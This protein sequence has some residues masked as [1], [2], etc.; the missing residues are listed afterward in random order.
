MVSMD[1]FNQDP[2]KTIQLTAAIEK[3]PYVP[4][5]LETLKVFVDKPIRTDTLFVEQRDGQ[6]SL[7]P[8]TDR[9]APRTQR[10]T[11]RR[12]ARPFVVPRISMADT[13]YAHE[14]AFIRD[15]G[16]ESA[17]M[18]IQKE[19]MRRT[20]GPTGLR[21]NLRFTQENHKLATIQGYL[22]DS[23][24]S[25]KFNWFSEFG[26]TPNDATYFD[27]TSKTAGMLRPKIANIVR[28]MKR[29]SK[30]AFT[31]GT[32]VYAL[33]GDQFWD[34]FITHPDIEKTYLNW[35]AAA[36]LRGGTAFE[37]YPFADVQWV[38]YRG[39]D[40]TVS[41]QA[42]LTNGSADA[43]VSASGLAQLTDGWYASGYGVPA[44]S[45]I[46]KGSGKITLS[47][48]FTGVTGTYLLNFGPSENGGG[49]ISIPTNKC[50]F[51]PVGAP[52]VFLRALAPAESVEFLGTLGKPEYLRMIPDRDRNEWVKFEMDSYP[53]HICTRPEMLFSGYCGAS[54][55]AA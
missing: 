49:V 51:F 47:S 46:T 10:T 32:K 31:A 7:L 52:D 17:L 20:V 44:G 43:S 24:G 39:S 12:E 22:L 29:K 16:T 28:T 13:V 21:N 18:Q 54:S 36:G 9:G 35:T 50:L 41:V 2:F 1:V 14:I 8:F 45:S 33:C 11:E 48:A 25:I 27:L 5:G 3:A 34:N 38:N 19:V 26:I 40:D 15:M 53:L 4:D 37:T 55:A 30:G 6:L 42:T 23:D